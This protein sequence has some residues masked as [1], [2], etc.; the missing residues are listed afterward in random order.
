MHVFVSVKI[1]DFEV[2]CF[3][4]VKDKVLQMLLSKKDIKVIPS[5][6]YNLYYGSSRN[7]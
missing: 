6:I 7:L 1:H 5:R 3:Q 4:Y 2:R